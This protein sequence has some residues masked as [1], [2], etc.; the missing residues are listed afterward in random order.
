MATDLGSFGR[1][2]LLLANVLAAVFAA[3]FV[4]VVYTAPELIGAWDEAGRTVAIR[5]RDTATVGLAALAAG[6]LLLCD[7]LY[8]VYGRRPRAPLRHIVSEA[9]GGL[10][11]VSRDALE[12]ALRATGES[13]E[14]ITRLRV[15]IEP[16][17]LKRVV[18]RAHF[19]CPEGV[20]LQEA[21]R[22]LRNALTERCKELVRLPEG[23]RI[24]YEI[25]FVGFG[26]KLQRK[27]A[28]P[29]PPREEEPAPFTGPQYPIDDEE[30]FPGT[31]TP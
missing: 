4:L 7:L 14:E 21:S 16:G 18:V 13:L 22:L 10:V 15:A 29:P 27:G 25:E 26:G 24:D 17:G 1:R 23:S 20:S 6:A 19:M 11:R 12:G 2:L 31:R 28:E 3:G 9:P 30:P 5:L 8:L